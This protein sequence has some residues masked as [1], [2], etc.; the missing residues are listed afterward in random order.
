MKLALAVVFGL[1]RWIAGLVIYLA[2]YQGVSNIFV[3]LAGGIAG[4]FVAG[5]WLAGAL[6]GV[7]GAFGMLV[8]QGLVGDVAAN[9]G[10]QTPLLV[11]GVV[12]GL[13]GGAL[14]L[15]IFWVS[16]RHSTQQQ[17]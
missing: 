9:E 11:G 3:S 8:L 14:W 16:R 12:G 1:F 5:N 2:V 4:G 7:V 13:V 15:G 10:V 17:G 6:V